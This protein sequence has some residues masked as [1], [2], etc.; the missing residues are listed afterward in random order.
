MK[1]FEYDHFVN[2]YETDRMCITHHSNYVRWMEEARLA[3]LDSIGWGL[4]RFENEGIVS[5]VVSLECRYKKTTTYGDTIR[6]E[7]E[8]T[9]F[10]GVKLKLR[11]VMRNEKDEIVFEGRSE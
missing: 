2:Y 1:P 9:E 4:L 3:L 5:P 11:Y 6:V 7:T 10:N 8:L